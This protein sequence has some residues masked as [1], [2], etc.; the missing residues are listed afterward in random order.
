LKKKIPSTHPP[1]SVEV[2]FLKSYLIFFKE[3]TSTTSHSMTISTEEREEAESY[4]LGLYTKIG[5]GCYALSRYDCDRAIN[6]FKSLPH[7]QANTP[8]IVSRLARA[9]YENRNLSEVDL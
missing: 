4:L 7:P 3:P 5:D 9:F 8:Y 6:L 1:L 2:T